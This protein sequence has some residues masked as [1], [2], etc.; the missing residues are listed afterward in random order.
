[1]TLKEK[2]VQEIEQRNGHVQA[3]LFVKSFD[4]FIPTT[5]AINH[6]SEN[7]EQLKQNEIL[8]NNTLRKRGSFVKRKDK[9]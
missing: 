4:A 3:R 9:I 7:L 1:M 8:L 5:L 2:D 6:S